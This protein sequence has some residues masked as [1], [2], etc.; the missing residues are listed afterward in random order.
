MSAPRRDAASPWV[1]SVRDLLH[2]AGLQRE[3]GGQ[4]SAPEGL[5]TPVLGVPAGDPV[6]VDIRLESVHEGV[7]VTGTADVELRG[8]CARCLDP[9]E[10]GLTVD[11]QELY[12]TDPSDTDDEDQQAVVDETIDLEPVLRDAV[13][14]ALPFQPVCRPDC[15]GLCADCGIRL[16]DAPDGHGHER[17]DPRWAA[18]AALAETEQTSTPETEER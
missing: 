12:L 2:S 14:T 13:V 8:E 6:D 3:V 18:L 16:E 9:L 7:L 17:V 11:L 5:S 15:E 4:W 1:I 10:V